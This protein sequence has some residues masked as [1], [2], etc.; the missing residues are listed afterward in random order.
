MPYT[1]L[2]VSFD[3][4]NNNSFNIRKSNRSN[5]MEGVLQNLHGHRSVCWIE[6]DN[7]IEEIHIQEYLTNYDEF[8]ENVLNLTNFNDREYIRARL[9]I[10]AWQY[11][12]SFV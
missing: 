3:A 1:Y 9:I 10:R 5:Y 12:A 4:E 8:Q 6:L 7:P 11:G 2:G